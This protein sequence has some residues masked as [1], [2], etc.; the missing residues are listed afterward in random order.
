MIIISPF[1]GYESVTF[2]AGIAALVRL[3]QRFEI[4]G[5]QS[6][7]MHPVASIAVRG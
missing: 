4:S 5:E 6:F 7:C 3:G 2:L 1:A